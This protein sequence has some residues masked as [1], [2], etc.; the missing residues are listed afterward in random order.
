MDITKATRIQEMTQAVVEHMGFHTQVTLREPVCEGQG[1]FICNIRVEGDSNLLIGQHGVNLQA[2]QHLIRLLAKKEF[3][4]N[5]VFSLDV[6]SY[7]EQKSQAL[8][9]EAHQAAQTAIQTN[10]AVTLRP[11]AG[12]ERKIIHAELALI[13]EVATESTGANENRKVI[14]KPAIAA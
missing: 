6:N 3:Q 13:K 10:A 1:D 2:L 9:K 12:Y 8:V 11:M 4:E 5:I 14:V 7:W